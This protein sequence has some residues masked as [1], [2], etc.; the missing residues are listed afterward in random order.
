M[1]SLSSAEEF[2]P[3]SGTW[4]VAGT[5]ATPWPCTSWWRLLPNGQVLVAGGNKDESSRNLSTAGKSL[6]IE[7]LI[8]MF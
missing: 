1:E 6:I 3:A 5:L 7:A 8:G 2:N 4:T